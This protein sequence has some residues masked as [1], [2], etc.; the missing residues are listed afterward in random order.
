MEKASSEKSKRAKTVNVPLVQIADM[1]YTLKYLQRE[2][3]LNGVAPCLFFLMTNGCL[4]NISM[5]N[6]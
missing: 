2:R 1:L 5:I 4:T 3:L 6:F